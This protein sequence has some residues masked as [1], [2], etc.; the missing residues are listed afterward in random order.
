M[1]ICS[2]HVCGLRF[3]RFHQTRTDLAVWRETD[4]KIRQVD[5]TARL[6]STKLMEGMY[7]DITHTLDVLWTWNSARRLAEYSC[8]WRSFHRS[9]LKSIASYL[10]MKFGFIHTWGC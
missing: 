1:N 3:N 2:Y 8:D 10:A 4:G 7:E 5:P 9:I 6:A